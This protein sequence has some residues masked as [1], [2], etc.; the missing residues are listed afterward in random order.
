MGLFSCRCSHVLFWL[1]LLQSSSL[2][3]PSCHAQQPLGKPTTAATTTKSRLN[4]RDAP[5][6]QHKQPSSLGASPT[7]NTS[8]PPLNELQ[9]FIPKQ[10]RR[11]RSLIINPRRKNNYVTQQQQL[12]SK[13]RQMYVTCFGIVFV[14]WVHLLL[15]FRWGLNGMFYFL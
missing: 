8:L 6:K 1:A 10:R 3:L 14:W 2:H 9:D 13:K 15:L 12:P 5:T 11:L 4:G 7:I